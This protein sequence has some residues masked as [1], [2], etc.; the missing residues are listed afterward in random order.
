MSEGV[1]IKAKRTAEALAAAMEPLLAQALAPEKVFADDELVDAASEVA[2]AVT[3]LEQAKFSRGEIAARRALE[4]RAARLRA[5]LK[6][7]KG[8]RR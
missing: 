6:A 3:A 4:L 8:G 7:R 5:V 2:K 1:E